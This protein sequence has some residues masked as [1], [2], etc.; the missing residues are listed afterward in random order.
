MTRQMQRMTAERISFFTNITHEF[1][2]PITLIIGPIERALKLTDNPKVTQQLNY[3]K[4]NSKYLLSLVNQLMDFR[5]M[6]SGKIDII[7]AEGDIQKFIED[8][9][10]L[11]RVYGDERKIQINTL[12]HLSSN[13]ISFDHEAIRKVIT[14]LVGNA[15]KFTPDGGNI[16]IYTALLSTATCGN[17]SMLYLSVKDNGTGIPEG[18]IEKVFD[19][20]YQGKSQLQYPLV[21]SGSSGIGLY[22]CKKLVEVYGGKISVKNN[23][24]KGCTFRVLL[25]VPG[26]GIKNESDHVSRSE[27]YLTQEPAKDQEE[28][29]MTI[30]IVEDNADMRS[31]IRSILEDRFNVAEASNGKEALKILLSQDIDF[32][33]SDLMMPDIDG[34]EL[35]RQVKE[36][37]SISHIPFVI[38]TAKTDQNSKLDGFKNGVDDYILKPFDEEMLLTRIQNI[39]DNKNR[40]KQHFIKDMEVEKLNIP[41]ESRDKKFVDQ[42]M[43]VVHNN[44]KNA[45]FDVGD[46]AEAL[47][48]SR[49]LLNK[50]LQS[51]IG[52]SANQLMRSYRMKIAKELILKNRSTRDMNISEIAFS[53]G[54]NDSK[55]FTRCFTKQYGISPSAMLKGETNPVGMEVYTQ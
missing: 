38:L 53:V 49:S 48:V 33:I 44:Y 15:I 37:F 4:R 36:N 52:E 43:E 13:T 16:E 19:Q 45:Y 22:F 23:R 55:Y 1:R 14:N 24:E 25:P 51:L 39:L 21:G 26:R 2:T 54:F 50:K 46:F 42:V 8:I 7:T 27:Y 47:G 12:F 6:E 5:K 28:N 41:T 32:I 9:V 10:L 17:D 35:G 31:Y 11:F 18:E 40:Y 29:A 30:L 20:F 3:V 34:L